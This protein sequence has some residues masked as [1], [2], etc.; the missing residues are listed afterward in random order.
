MPPRRKAETSGPNAK[1]AAAAAEVV[2][3]AEWVSPGDLIPW[4]QNPRF[5]DHAVDK[6]AASIKE[7][8]W[9]DVIVARRANSMVISGHTRLKA[10][11]KLGLTKVPVRFIDVDDRAARQLALAS[12]KLGE[13]AAWDDEK[14]AAILSELSK[15]AENLDIPMDFNAL[16]FSQLELGALLRHPGAWGGEDAADPNQINGYD[17]AAET[18]VIT[19]DMVAAAD[20]ERV[21][22]TINGAL[23]GA[24]LPYQGKAF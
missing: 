18:F 21:L 3:A 5:N 19:V 22:A 1:P 13:L 8:G 16:G 14:L 2:S 17:P 4:E 24:G 12:N 20:K 15:E 11:L 6:V 10:A 9:A 7:F 23:S